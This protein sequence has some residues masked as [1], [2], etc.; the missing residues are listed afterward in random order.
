MVERNTT[1][2]EYIRNYMINS[3]SHPS[4]FD[5]EADSKK[6]GMK[7]GLTSIYRILNNMVD[8]NELTT[9]ITKDNIVHYDY[10]RKD[11]YHFVC[12]KCN[13]II[14][15]SD[16]KELFQKISKDHNLELDEIQEVIIYGTCASCSSK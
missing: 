13:K 5:I 16:E 8:N 3:F 14:D 4:A 2:K 15:I 6:A 10:N 12:K 7:I 11:H 9:I 1:Q